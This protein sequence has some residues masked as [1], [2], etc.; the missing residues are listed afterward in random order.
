VDAIHVDEGA[1]AFA[2]AGRARRP[3]HLVA[4]PQL[5]A[6]DLGSRDVDVVGARFDPPKPQEAVTLRGD[7]KRPGRLRGIHL[8]E[9]LPFPI[10]PWLTLGLGLRLGLSGL[11]LAGFATGGDLVDELLA[12]QEPE[13]GHPEL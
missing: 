8:F 10:R 2:A 12:V 5:T 3:G 9:R 13:A 6:A 4:R 11:G 1:V 7:F